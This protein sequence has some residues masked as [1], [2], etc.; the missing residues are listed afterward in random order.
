M[1]FFLQLIC[2]ELGFVYNAEATLKPSPNPDN[3]GSRYSQSF[4]CK[5]EHKRLSECPRRNNYC[6]KLYD[7]HGNTCVKQPGKQC[8]V[9]IRCI[10]PPDVFP[11]TSTANKS[12][13][14]E[15]CVLKQY[16]SN[17]PKYDGFSRF[18][19]WP[20]YVKRDYSIRSASINLRMGPNFAKVF[21]PLIR[22]IDNYFKL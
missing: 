21:N 16:A 13:N 5:P 22:L 7:W 6:S 8:T 17:H 2:A 1:V 15:C 4:D 3:P 14:I 18:R 19:A 12:C 11:L 20:K 10:Q 9:G